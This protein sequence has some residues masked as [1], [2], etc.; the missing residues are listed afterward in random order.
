MS[1]YKEDWP[2]EQSEEL[3][4]ILALCGV[5]TSRFTVYNDSVSLQD[6]P[7]VQSEELSFILTLCGVITSRFT[8]YND[9]LQ[10]RLAPGAVR[11][12][13]LHPHPVWGDHK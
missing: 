2:Q 6:W 4:F 12:T 5:I 3:S 11:G 1:A 9:S 10:G 7:Q 8:V 13:Q